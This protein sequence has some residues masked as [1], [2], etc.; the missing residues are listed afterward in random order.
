L[1]PKDTK[2]ISQISVGNSAKVSK[3]LSRPLATLPSSAPPPLP[4]TPPPPLP[5]VFSTHPRIVRPQA[6][7]SAQ[8]LSNDSILQT[9][10]NNTNFSFGN[11]NTNRSVRPPLK[12]HSSQPTLFAQN[13]E[14]ALETTASP[15]SKDDM[16]IRGIS[17]IENR[18]QAFY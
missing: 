14:S 5:S 8:Q 4:S 9:K 1:T 6:N 11:D 15:R 13:A 17:Q 16:D 7:H 18:R 12:R 10:S 3:V 2:R